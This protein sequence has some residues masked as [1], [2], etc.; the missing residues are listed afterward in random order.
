MSQVIE[1]VYEGNGIVRLNR[2]P[3]GVKP[4]ERLTVLVVPVPAS[5]EFKVERL[6]FEGLQRQIADFEKRYSLKSPEFYARFLRG[7]MGDARDYI[8]WAGLYELRQ[9]ISAR[10]QAA[11]A[12]G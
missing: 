3:E 7:E 9:R 2:E 12:S 4:N 5:K 11:P 8:V 6:G 1:A 10:K